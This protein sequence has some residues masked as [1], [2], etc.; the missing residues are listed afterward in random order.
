[1]EKPDQWA[2]KEVLD[3]RKQELG[4]IE[5]RDETLTNSWANRNAIRVDTTGVIGKNKTLIQRVLDSV[6]GVRDD[7]SNLVWI[8]NHPAPKTTDR[9]I[10]REDGIK[11]GFYYYSAQTV[12]A[13]F[14]KDKGKYIL[15]K[16]NIILKKIEKGDLY[17]FDHDFLNIL[18]NLGIID[19]DE[20]KEKIR[21]FLVNKGDE[22]WNKIIAFKQN[23]RCVDYLSDRENK[24]LFFC[25]NNGYIS[26]KMVKLLPLDE[27]ETIDKYIDK[28]CKEDLIKVYYGNLFFPEER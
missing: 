4:I 6:K 19:S 8:S 11:N 25:I 2:T 13:S 26:H 15:N 3:S 20:I 10:L 14:L 7:N 28:Y 24:I 23:R 18:V 9:F 22:I 21:A 27:G 17:N 16:K 1:M 12:E 5:T